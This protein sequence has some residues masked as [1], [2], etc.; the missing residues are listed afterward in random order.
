M[1]QVTCKAIWATANYCKYIMQK[2][3][4]MFPT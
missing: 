4:L 1:P 3:N 2:E